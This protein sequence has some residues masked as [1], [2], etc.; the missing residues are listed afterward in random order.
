MSCPHNTTGLEHS[1]ISTQPSEK[2]DYTT[3]NSHKVQCGYEGSEEDSKQH[4][5]KQ[6]EGNNHPV[7]EQPDIIGESTTVNLK[8]KNKSQEI[9][10]QSCAQT[11]IPRQLYST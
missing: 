11:F 4:A 2:E 9:L 10:I 6:K 3:F 5:S 1:W 7:H 8:L